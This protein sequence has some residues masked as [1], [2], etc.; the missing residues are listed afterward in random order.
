[1]PEGENAVLGVLYRVAHEPPPRLQHGGWLAPL[2]Q[3]TMQQDPDARISMEEVVASLRAGPEGHDRTQVLTAVPPTPMVTSSAVE[4]PLP[5]RTAVR[6][7]TGEHDRR[8]RGRRLALLT[9]AAVLVI[10]AIAAVALL[11][12]GDDDP[13]RTALPNNTDA[14]SSSGAS[15]DD[16]SPSEQ[17]TA[18]DLE[19][20]ASTYVTTAA[21][22]PDAGFALLTPAY[23]ERSPEYADF[24]GRLS[25]PRMIDVESDPAEMTVTYTY[26]YNFQGEGN[27]TER[28]TL[29]LVQEGDQLLIDDAVSG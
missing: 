15:A 16:G 1:V 10:G 21:D 11:V 25:N 12:A 27:V 7:G 14:T 18:E 24:W 23:Q 8:A 3:A 22:D 5:E 19:S 17:P 4:E 28:V 9:L 20:L 2:V 13:D 26:R 29:F 6:T